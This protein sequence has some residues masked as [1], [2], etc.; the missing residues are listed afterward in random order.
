M[1]PRNKAMTEN[2]QIAHSVT[3]NWKERINPMD[4]PR[5]LFTMFKR[6]ITKLSKI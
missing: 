1:V 5:F 6:W 4:S 2:M 3:H